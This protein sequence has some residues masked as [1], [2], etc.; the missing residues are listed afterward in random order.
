MQKN[1]YATL[2]VSRSADWETIHS[3]FRALARRYHPD[4]GERSSSAVKFSDLMEAYETLR[5]PLRREQYDLHL[6]V[7]T[8]R[9]RP[10]AE[11]LF[12][13]RYAIQRV[14]FDRSQPTLDDLFDE[15]MRFIDAEFDIR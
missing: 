5:D 9:R 13:P 8:N 4:T 15:I 3:A 10:A 11:P 14:H 2:G 7:M 12:A 6:D 1:H